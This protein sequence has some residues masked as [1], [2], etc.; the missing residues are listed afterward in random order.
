MN[1]S[2]KIAIAAFLAGLIAGAAGGS[3]TQRA[4][5]RHAMLHRPSPQEMMDRLSRDLSL[6]KAQRGAI[7]AVMERHKP[8]FEA[9]R[10]TTATEFDA[11]RRA[12][13]DEIKQQLNPVQ[14]HK[15]EE[16]TARFLKGM[17]PPLLEGM[18]SP[19]G[20]MPPLSRETRDGR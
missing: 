5:H 18:P 8:K 15:F 12:A 2:G 11:I 3:W 6:D 10:R 19:P 14:R 13:D 4:I 7:S 17:P 20:G 9:L 1:D 16:M